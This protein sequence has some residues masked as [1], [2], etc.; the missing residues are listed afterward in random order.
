M[1]TK[2][3]YGVALSLCLS[4]MSLSCTNNDGLN[5]ND[6]NVE[7]NQIKNT[8]QADNWIITS[9][10]DSGIDETNHFTGYN[11]TFNSNGT[12]IA[13]NG[14]ET[15]NGTWSVMDSNNSNDDSYS[16]EDI[17]FNIFFPSPANFNDDLTEDW[18]IVN[19]SATKIDLVHVSGGNGGT[20]TLT[21]EKN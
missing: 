10:F 21:F 5:I 12:L 16:I 17:D 4:L 3:I 19:H 11:F 13:T 8:V 20:D 15:I 2:F 1:K 14:N 6:N 7:I 18:K 9:F